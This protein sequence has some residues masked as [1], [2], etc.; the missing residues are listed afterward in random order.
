[1]I[2]TVCGGKGGVGKSTVALNLA[3]ALDGVLVDADLGMADLPTD[4]G[5]TLFDVLAGRLD[6]DEA[7]RSE[8]AVGVLPAGRSLAG[9]RSVDPGALEG[10]LSTLAET[11]RTVVVDAPAGFSADAALSIVAA[12]CCV[13]VTTPEPATLADAVRTRSL[14]RELGTDLAA[15]VLNR[16]DVTRDAVTETLGGPQF[17]VPEHD[18]VHEAQESGLPVAYTDAPLEPVQRFEAVADHLERVAADRRQEQ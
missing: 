17:A 1:M 9:A 11:Y 12:D 7:V 18:A 8:W 3:G 6:P 14:A 10:V 4:G 16:A 15:V 5:P 2:V 13:L